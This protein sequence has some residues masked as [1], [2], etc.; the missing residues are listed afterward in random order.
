VNSQPDTNGNLLV[1]RSAGNPHA[2]FVLE[3]QLKLREHFPGALQSVSRS[4]RCATE[5]P[6][7]A[8]HRPFGLCLIASLI[9]VPA[10]WAESSGRAGSR[11]SNL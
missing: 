3:P 4:G 1:E 10:R 7:S 6:H 9:P 11:L 2:T 8:S 5:Q